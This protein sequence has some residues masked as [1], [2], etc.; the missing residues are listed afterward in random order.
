VE[1]VTWLLDVNGNGVQF[2]PLL[3]KDTVRR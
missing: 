2:L 3:G 1:G